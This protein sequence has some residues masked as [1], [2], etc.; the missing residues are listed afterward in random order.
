M[1]SSS[2][3]SLNSDNGLNWLKTI[4]WFFMNYGNNHLF[5]NYNSSGINTIKTFIADTSEYN[6]SQLDRFNSPS[7]M[8]SELF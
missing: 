4:V 8:L 7:R 2:I 1:V 6:W 3:H 5:P